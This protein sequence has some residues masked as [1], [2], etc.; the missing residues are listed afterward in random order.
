MIRKFLAF[1]MSLT[2]ILSGC[3]QGTLSN[4][5]G[6]GNSNTTP[7]PAAPTPTTAS[8]TIKHV[9]IIFG[10]N[11]SFDHYFG[12]YPNALNLPGET[13]F[14]AAAGTP[15]P[16]NY[17]KTPSLLFNNPNTNAL[18]LTGATNPFR[19]SPAQALTSDQSHGYTSEQSAFDNGKMD[20][21]PLSVGTADNAS[22]AQTSGAPA[23]S[24]T[25]GEAMGYFDGNS[26]TAIWNYAQ[27]Y[28]MSDS[29]FS[30]NFG[31]S[32]P[33]A[34]NLISGQ[35]NG[36]VNSLNLGSSAVA[37][38]NGGMT[39][40]SDA[41]PYADVCSKTSQYTGLT[42]KNVGD[43]LNAAN[44]TWGWFQ[45]GFDLTVTNPGGTTGCGRS[46]VLSVSGQTGA[47]SDYVPHHQPFQYYASTA[48]P[49]HARP[50][51]VA[52]IGTTDAAKHQYD[53]HD[54]TDALAAGNLPTVSFLKAPALQ[55][56]HP[57]NSDPLDEGVFVANTINALENSSFWSSTAVI[58][59]YDDSDGWYDHVSNLI[60]GSATTADTVNGAG[61]CIS[62][63]GAQSALPGVD[64]QPHAQ[65][66][67]GYGPRQPLL[68]I[69]PWAKKNY[70]DHT[71]T[72]QSSILR[73]V[74]DTFLSNQRIGN[75]SFDSIAGSLNPMFDFS[76]AAAPPN[77]AKVLL[78]PA[79]GIVT[80]GN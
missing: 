24:S 7:P 51:S 40:I 22:L 34:V 2:L 36:L 43:L 17:I 47:V 35:T 37:D 76:N 56:G 23:I 8:A 57:G 80:S 44:I 21:F 78:N 63:A 18:N 50:T 33:G 54:F 46:T 55:D 66:R 25:K 52:A 61:I 60:N 30:T 15:I 41:D 73:F 19:L 74:E 12:T 5:A 27:H 6:N 31:P 4:P 20:L 62:A 79:N 49:T 38:G 32:T 9:V 29:S 39:L 59:A 14:T 28:A 13:P 64:G 3:G 53:I 67:C 68:V 48:N 72:D 75:G 10:E 45:G 71:V 16:N 26:V 77:A 42:G 70:I 1:T 11:I 58:I 65:G 69:S